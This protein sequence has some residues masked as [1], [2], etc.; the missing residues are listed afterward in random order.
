MA[1]SVDFTTLGTWQADSVTVGQVD[2]A[3]SDLRRH[4]ER[5]AVRTSVLTLVVVGGLAAFAFLNVGARWLLT[6]FAGGAY[7]GAALY[8]PWYA[9]GMTL[10]GGV[11]V[12]IATHQSHGRAA[13]LAILLPLSALEPVLLSA[14]HANLLQLVQVLD[15]WVDAQPAM[16]RVS[17]TA[18][19][20]AMELP[21]DLIFMACSPG[22]QLGV[23]RYPP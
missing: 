8:L 11:A 10:L 19:R 12:L 17:P 1:E 15:I 13:F 20:A 16:T 18:A 3:L 14:F 5:A 23:G 4:E 7:A 22:L 21:S 9:V 2:A 6:A